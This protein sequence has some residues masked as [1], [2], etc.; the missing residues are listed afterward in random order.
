MIAHKQD[1]W[2]MLP[3]GIVLA[4][5]LWLQRSLHLSELIHIYALLFLVKR[6]VSEVFQDLATLT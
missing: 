6:G 1:I 2:V 3:L 4:M 5:M